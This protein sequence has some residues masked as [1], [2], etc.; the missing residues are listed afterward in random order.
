MQTVNRNPTAAEVR[1]FGLVIFCG[2]AVIGTLLW[3]QGCAED[4]GWHWT[5]S[6]L[7]LAAVILWTMGAATLIVAAISYSLGRGIYVVWMTGATYLGTVMTFV[8]LSL[9][10]V[11]LLPVFS[12]I[13]F[14]DPLRLKL[15][16]PGESYW[17]D[18]RPHESTLERTIRP[19]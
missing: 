16:A 1:K 6:G 9:L 5:S 15:A 11:L 12:L 19:F 7:Q 4:S 3:W 8:M 2:F 18:H 10:F 14:K 17:E 13:R